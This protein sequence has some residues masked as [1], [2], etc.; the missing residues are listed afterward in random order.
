[1]PITLPLESN[2]A[3]SKS[4]IATVEHTVF[5]T[6]EVGQ[7]FAEVAVELI[8]GFIEKLVRDL[9]KPKREASYG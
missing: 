2:I 5:V 1:M 8:G 9:D 7:E 4:G 3:A 6:G